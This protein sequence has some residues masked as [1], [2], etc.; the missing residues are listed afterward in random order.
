MLFEAARRRGVHEEEG[1]GYVDCVLEEREKEK[2]VER[3]IAKPKKG[4]TRRA[5]EVNI[6]EVQRASRGAGNT[7]DDVL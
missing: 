6:D 4:R 5:R 2:G 1:R 3:E 7:G